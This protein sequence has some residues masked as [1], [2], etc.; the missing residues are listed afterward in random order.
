MNRN[1]LGCNR[2]RVCI[3]KHDLSRISFV[4]VFAVSRRRNHTALRNY[5]IR[6]VP[7][8]RQGNRRRHVGANEYKIRVVV[9][10]QA[11]R[12]GHWI[13]LPPQL[14]RR[15]NFLDFRRERFA[16]KRFK[17][18]Y[19]AILIEVLFPNQN[20]FRNTDGYFNLL[21][22]RQLDNRLTGSDNLVIFNKLLNDNAVKGGF[23]DCVCQGVFR[24][25][26]T[27]LNS[28]NLRF[29]RFNLFR[30]SAGSRLFKLIF[31]RLSGGFGDVVI[32]LGFIVHS[33]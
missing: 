9:V 6:V 28:G 2:R 13:G 14:N 12:Q 11:D 8:E 26:E 1:R 20:R 10:R 15:T 32:H 25:F 30:T 5:K 24:R 3:V 27:C 19:K 31:Q 16:G 22:V 33:F 29:R 21:R 4:G 23:Q 18:T 7:L 17:G